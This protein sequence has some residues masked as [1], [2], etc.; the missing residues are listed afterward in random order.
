MP[1]PVPAQQALNRHPSRRELRDR[2]GF[3]ETG[4]S[5]APRCPDF[6]EVESI[7]GKVRWRGIDGRPEAESRHR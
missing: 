2:L 3:P 4:A 7:K 6:P 5:L 1:D